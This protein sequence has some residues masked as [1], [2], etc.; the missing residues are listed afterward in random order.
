[1]P[2][3]ACTVHVHKPEIYAYRLVNPDMQACSVAA[4]LLHVRLCAC[5]RHHYAH[6]HLY[7]VM[8]C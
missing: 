4:V 3:S 5:R 7:L 8:Q 6:R 1:M 2:S